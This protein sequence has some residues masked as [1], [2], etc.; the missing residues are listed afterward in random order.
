MSHARH[1]KENNC[2][3]CG[4]EVVGKFCHN[5]G[6]PNIE[7]KETLWQLINHFF[8]DITHFDGKIFSSLRLVILKPGFL[9]RQY[10]LGKR[11]SYLNPIRMYLFVSA[12]FFL[13]FFSIVKINPA[14][15][16][17]GITDNDIDKMDSVRFKKFSKALNNGK[18][19]SRDEAKKRNKQFTISPGNYKTKAQYDSALHAG[20]KHNWVERQLIYK[21]I[22]LNEKYNHD[23]NTIS[24]AIINKL[25]HTIPQMLF[26]LLPLFALVLKLLYIRRKQFYYVDHAIFTLHF[27]IFVFIDMLVIFGV[28]K[29][30][31]W[32]H[33]RL[34]KYLITV[35]IIAIFFYLY[36]ALRNFYKQRRAKTIFKFIILL[37]MFFIIFL[38]LFIALFFLSIF[39]I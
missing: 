30:F 8:A 5:C 21:E 12:I 10:I 26:V 33:W 37:F 20:K 2:L 14:T 15:I 3:N 38:F 16:S 23:S 4:T 35:L 6:Q 18:L 24:A 7:P 32:L 13:I 28:G 1:R 29:L 39:G 17:I 34:L 27:Y 25:V 31:D 9:S 36:K 11:M 22:E 19:L